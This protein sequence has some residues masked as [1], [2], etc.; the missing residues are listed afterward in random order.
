M[1]FYHQVPEALID[2]M[3]RYKFCRDEEEFWIR[4]K[5]LNNLPLWNFRR[6]L[7]TML[8]KQTTHNVQ[9]A[10]WNEKCSPRKTTLIHR[11]LRKI[12]KNQGERERKKDSYRFLHLSGT[13]TNKRAKNKN[14]RSQSTKPSSTLRLKMRLRLYCVKS[15]Q[16]QVI[17]Q[18]H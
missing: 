1:I 11:Q 16:R 5:W 12:E 7:M 15:N 3:E 18:W 9:C 17:C 13:K 4:D 14:K 10:M 6:K 2:F 8:S